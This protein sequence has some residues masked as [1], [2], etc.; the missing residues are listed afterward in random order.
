MRIRSKSKKANNPSPCNFYWKS[1]LFITQRLLHTHMYEMKAFIWYFH[2]ILKVEFAYIYAGFSN[3]FPAY[4]PIH[5]EFKQNHSKF[6]AD[7]AHVCTT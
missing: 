7:D 1:H 3:F 4:V 2:E 6:P 5:I